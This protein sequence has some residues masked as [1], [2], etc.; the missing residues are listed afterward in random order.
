MSNIRK[1]S[2]IL[3]AAAALT[4]C[5]KV[6]PQAPANQPGSDTT[7]FAATM[8]NMRLAEAADRQVCQWVQ[9]AD[10]AYV[11]DSYGYWY[12]LYRH[13]DGEPI[14][15]GDRVEIFYSVCTLDGQLIED[16]Q[17]TVQVSH[18]ET[19][20]AIDVFLTDMRD[21]EAV[22]IISPYYTAYGKDG[23]ETV[24]PLTNCVIDITS[25]KIIH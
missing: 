20:W 9:Q 5:K 24:P 7:G 21:G 23:N 13:S 2:I 1:Y 11:L 3:L 8:L 18:R 12:C 16:C 19:I 17:T 14:K 10:T 15:D 25:V 6:A 22:R 4:G